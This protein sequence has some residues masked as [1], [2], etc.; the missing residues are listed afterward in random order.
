MNWT[1]AT[2]LHIALLDDHTVVRHGLLELLGEESDFLVVG[3]FASS[4]ELIA[5]LRTTPAELL[6]IDFALAPDDVDGLNLIRALSIRFPESKILVISAHYN[7]ATVALA[8][9]AGARGF[10][11]KN[12]PL[13]DI[14]G[15][16]R[17]VARGHTYLNPALEVE[18]AYLLSDA[19]IQDD[20]TDAVSPVLVQDSFAELSPRERE[21]LRCCL[22]GL[23]VT[24]IAEKFD[25]S[26]K[27][28]STQKHAAFRKLGIRT[29]NELFKMHRQ[30]GM[31]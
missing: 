18:F 23:S 21:V 31:L 27:T 10:V 22:N 8:L 29:D 2:P 9:R 25:R 16:I 11:G 7:P 5:E 1:G 30:L 13:A 6:L 17:T 14:V 3:A 26:T 19:A 15:A 28:I 4:R 12:Q 24:Q 20:H